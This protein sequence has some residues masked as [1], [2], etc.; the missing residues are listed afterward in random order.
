MR[1][2]KGFPKAPVRFPQDPNKIP[3]ESPNNTSSIS[4]RFPQVPIR[5]PED[6]NWFIVGDD[7]PTGLTQ[8][9]SHATSPAV[10]AKHYQ[11]FIMFKTKL[12]TK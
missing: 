12:S 10:F 2:P 6:I 8:N 1:V 9:D 4:V 7:I 5:F 3:L 11:P